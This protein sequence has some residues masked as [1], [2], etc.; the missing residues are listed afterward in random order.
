MKRSLFKSFGI[1]LGMI[2]FSACSIKQ[3]PQSTLNDRLNFASVQTSLLLKKAMASQKIPRTV[4]EDGH[5]HWTREGFDWTEGFF[6]GTCWYLY[7]FTK[8]SKW[9]EAASHFQKKF[10]DHRLMPLYHDLGFVF[11]CSYGQGYRITGNNEYK[12]ILIDAGNTLIT[13]FNPKVGCIRSWDVDKGWQSKRGW[14]FP[15]IID[16]MM[17]LEMLF[18]LSKITGD[19]KYE[20]V[21]ISHADVTLKNH[22]RPDISSYHVVDYD[23]ITGEVR[24]KQTAQG[25]AH[26]SEWA[27]GQTWGLYGYTIC[28]RYTKDIKYLKQAEKIADFIINHPSIPSDR[29]P[30]WDYDAPKIPNEPRD[31]SA[32]AITASA[33]IELD[34]YS[35]KDYLSEAKLI[36]SNL[37]SA[38][39]LA[40]EGENHNFILMHS[41]G[42]IPHNNEIDVPLNY[43]DYY[44]V[45]ALMRLYNLDNKE[46]NSLKN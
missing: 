16:N 4:T 17:N 2:A 39:Y 5:M 28:Y 12:K 34:G 46:Q 44:Y 42:S 41:V 18:E 37:S 19:K 7:E 29:I 33:L 45:E 11:H 3:T 38:K 23:S 6:P 20:D 22:F 40:A 8:D 21:A 14:E 32:A 10:E 31:A 36:L 9:K 15:V 26:E 30:Y 43:A 35:D 27:R 1:I 24:N 25:Y 13:R